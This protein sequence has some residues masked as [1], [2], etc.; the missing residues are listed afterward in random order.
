MAGVEPQGGFMACRRKNF[1]QQPR[2]RRNAVS[3]CIN[4]FGE[5][6]N[7][8]YTENCGFQCTGFL[9]QLANRGR[10]DR[11]W[12]AATVRI[13][14]YNFCLA[15]VQASDMHFGGHSVAP[16]R[17][18]YFGRSGQV[19]CNHDHC[20]VCHRNS[21]TQGSLG[22][23]SSLNNRSLGFM[24]LVLSREGRPL[25]TPGLGLNARLDSFNCTLK[26]KGACSLA[27]LGSPVKLRPGQ[28]RLESRGTESGTLCSSD[29]DWFNHI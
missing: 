24:S 6:M 18:S 10:G 14:G 2:F 12:Q 20:W 22:P 9:G 17:P 19:V 26:M 13:D 21:P 1:T 23:A 5:K 3:S 7:Q 27:A 16:C 28:V 29:R 15:V 11:G 4:T 25:L 8:V